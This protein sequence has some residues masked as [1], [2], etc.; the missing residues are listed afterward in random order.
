M[1][2]RLLAPAIIAVALSIS[3]PALAGPWEDGVAAYQRG[4]YQSALKLWLPLATEGDARAENNLGVL[5][6][7][8]LGVAPDYETAANWYRRARDHGNQI[9]VQNLA[10]IEDWLICS[11]GTAAS[12]TACT[13]LIVD[14]RD[15]AGGQAQVRLYRGQ[16]YLASKTRYARDLAIADFDAAL[17]LQRDFPA[18]LVARGNAHLAFEYAVEEAMR[19]FSRA[20]ALEPAFYPAYLARADLSEREEE[21]ER[22]LADY[23]V[24]LELIPERDPASLE[25][26]GHIERLQLALAEPEPQVP[27]AADAKREPDGAEITTSTVTIEGE[28][29][30][31]ITVAGELLFGDE[32]RFVDAAIGAAG[33][34]V[35]LSG[36][37]GSLHAGFEIGKAIRL[38]N[39]ATIVLENTECA[40]ACALAWL[41]GRVRFMQDGARV[42][43]HAPYV[44][45]GDEP[46]PDSFGSAAVG[47]YLNEL[48]LSIHAIEFITSPQPED[49]GWLTPEVAERVGID[50]RLL[51]SSEVA[52]LPTDR[53]PS[54]VDTFR[55]VNVATDDVL[56]L[57]SGPGTQHGIVKGMPPDATGVSVFE[58][59]SVIGYGWQWCRAEWDGHTGWASACCLQEELRAPETPFVKKEFVWPRAEDPY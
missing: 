16:A 5:Y 32:Q 56:N 11:N 26:E 27:E 52:A 2:A 17:K 48:G 55:V 21:L 43:F 37:G 41:G 47:A 53:A 35:D 39:F 29:I 4:D 59:K 33:A 38:K 23:Q 58:C 36:P 8:G 28:L 13:R 46:R 15:V 54:K 19:D 12:I 34:I 49:M 25:V 3:C 1:R 50:L 14:Q 51:D 57:R 10:D 42:G 20:I 7:K 22:A 9:A 6:E 40:S 31:V 45:E 44:L 30:P 24:A 18:A